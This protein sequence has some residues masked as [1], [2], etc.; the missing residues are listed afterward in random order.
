MIEDSEG[1]RIRNLVSETYFPAG[2][3]IAWWDG[4]DD[5]GRDIDAA[6]HGLYSIPARFVEPGEYTARGIWRKDVKAF[7]EFSVYA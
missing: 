7:Y 2:R 4:T 1:M 6:K 3:N 5:L